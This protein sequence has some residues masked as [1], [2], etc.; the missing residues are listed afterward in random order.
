M[1][2]VILICSTALM[3]QDCTPQTARATIH[4]KVDGVVCGLP[5]QMG[6]DRAVAPDSTEYYVIKCRD[7]RR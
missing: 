7:T 2:I 6:F 4:Q 3:R 5:T 1:E